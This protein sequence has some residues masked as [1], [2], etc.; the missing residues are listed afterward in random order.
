MSFDG[1]MVRHVTNELN[2]TL[3]H[4]RITKIYQLGDFDFL[5]QVRSKGAHAILMSASPHSCRIHLTR[6]HYEKPEH[7]PMFCM[8]LRKHLEGSII[9]S[10]KQKAN[11]R[12]VS[13]ALKTTDEL[14]D[15]TEKY[16]I[17]EALGKDANL[18]VT[19]NTYRVLEA[20]HHTGPFDKATRTIVP[21]AQYTY[22]DDDRI[23]PFD[24]DALKNVLDN[25][26]VESSRD[27]LK[28]ISGISPL[29]LKEFDYRLRQSDASK[30]TVFKTMLEETH[31]HIKHHTRTVFYPI[32]LTHIDALETPYESPG[33]LLDAFFYT[34]DIA[35]KRKQK[36]KDLERFIKRQLE[37]LKIKKERLAKA[38]LESED[39][40]LDRLRGELLL[41]YQ[42]TI[43]KGART[44]TL[45]DYISNEPIEIPL[46]ASKT[47]L[48]NSRDYFKQYKKSKAAI[49]HIKKQ[50]RSAERDI[51]YFSLL[52]S[53]LDCATTLQDV[54]EIREELEQQ[55]FMKRRKR[56]NQK[57]R[58]ARY[59]IFEDAKGIKILVGKNNRQNTIVTHQEAEANDVWF[60]VQ[61]APGS[62]VVVK[63]PFPL[64][65]TTIRT[66]AMLAAYFSSMRHSTS[67]AVDYTEA[68]RVKKI[69]GKREGFVRYTHQKTIYIDPD[70][71]FIKALKT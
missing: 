60:H 33:A 38:L 62:H 19:D 51:A 1:I 42:H 69:P 7:P 32:R 37:R 64:S 22:P 50:Q 8:F 63:H 6:N 70:E 58:K 48:E 10:I 2:K 18:I 43:D 36:A 53:Q 61:N 15:L 28:H 21:S 4:A 40:T 56:P 65:E 57:R 34:R 45:T 16:L 35:E 49:P 44:V 29:F 46:D 24:Y 66:A 14:G 52:A 59:A 17:F 5:F 47:V 3:A 31:Y 26:M 55:G 20:L 27:Y 39:N 25:Q 12:V 9:T 54:E 41:A 68:K 13:I 11:D 30:E 67:V 23:N 71:T